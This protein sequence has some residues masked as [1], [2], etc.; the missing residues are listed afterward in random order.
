MKTK[1][2][3][4]CALCAGSFGLALFQAGGEGRTAASPATAVDS[5]QAEYLTP[6]LRASV[7]KLKADI[8]A[9]PTDA[10]N[11]EER[12]TVAWKWL[13][14]YSRKGGRVP[15]DLPLMTGVVKSFRNGSNPR[16]WKRLDSLLYD[17]RVRE[18]SPDAL[19]KLVSNTRGPFEA[20]SYQTIE[21]TV[22]IGRIPMLPGGGILVA[23]HFMS[24]FPPFQTRDPAAPNYVSVR[25]S[26]PQ[27][28]FT[29]T[30]NPLSGM[31]G[32][33]RVPTPAPTFQ[34]DGPPLV[35]GDTITVVFGDK[36]GGSPGFRV[37]SYSNDAFPLPLYI[38][39][40][41]N[42]NFL[43]LPISTYRVVGRSEVKLV[44]ALAPSVVKPGE[45]FEL[46][47]RSEDEYYNRASGG[48]PA[49]R[50]FLGDEL[51]GELAASDETISVL[52]GVS[53][54][55]PGVHRFA[56]RS[57]N[58][59]LRCLSNPVRVQANPPHR[60][61]WG[62][63]HGHGGFA[64]GQGT[65]AAFY[66]FA[67]DD[68]RL[69]F[70]THSEHD[71]WMDDHEWQVLIDNVRKYNDEGRFIA[72]LGYEWTMRADQGGHHNVLFRTPDNR[73]RVSLHEAPFLSGLYQGLAAQNDMRDVLVIPHAHEPGDWRQSHPQM[74]HL[75]EIMSMHGR[76]EWFG[77]MYLQHG[78]RVGFIAASDDHLS[79][80]GL[81]TP[82]IR[83][84]ADSGGLAAVLAP[85]KTSN[86]IFDAMKDLAAYATTGERM[87]LD[88]RLN[89]AR[90]G[91]DIPLPE[92]CRITGA[93]YGTAPIESITI[94][95][96]GKPIWTRECLAATSPETLELQFHSP[97][98]P[99]IHDSPRGWRQWEGTIAV[100]GGSVANISTPSLY[101]PRADAA[102]V[103]DGNPRIVDFKFATRGSEKG[104]LLE[105]V[106]ATVGTELEIS[107]IANRERYTTPAAFRRPAQLPAESFTFRVGD[108]LAGKAQHTINV[109]HFVDTVALRAIDVDGALDQS[110]AF[111]DPA[112]PKHGDYYYVRVRQ[113]DGGTAWSSPIWIGG[114]GP[115]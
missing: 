84:L 92:R 101:N 16:T 58:G 80:P 54:T 107:L 31:H 70:L 105:L 71:L 21:Q 78:H 83:G 4:L 89:G 108:A 103:R 37:Q 59:A 85:Q 15:I 77:I 104:I 87:I 66:E 82:L 13:N 45:R 22:T 50:I 91:T 17:L 47:I 73:S 94:V 25:C 64:E 46:T 61:Y 42:K 60:V 63:T 43:S 86:A 23:R 24:D 2:I 36:A 9:Q 97:S 8:D 39:L 110:F 6:E 3:L 115:Q 72:F 55:E 20:S 11:A 68:A 51:V 102:S 26:N 113:L 79:H 53:I 10:Q 27:A 48:A 98:D 28:R 75:V 111:T 93:V 34:L 5:P 14:A 35:P 67:R 1:L 33:F 29:V 38:D 74:E 30:S 65:P 49:W 40:E 112:P 41:A 106:G 18:E 62:E 99:E 7:Q 52:E 32:G 114:Y 44:R 90:M 81:P 100:R 19:G 109:E 56:V 96:N 88:Y 12:A 95:K 76:S 69:D 57:A